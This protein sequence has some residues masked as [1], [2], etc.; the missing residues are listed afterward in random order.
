[1]CVCVYVKLARPVKLISG[2][3]NFK[4]N[5]H[6]EKIAEDD[7]VRK[8]KYTYLSRERNQDVDKNLAWFHHILSIV[9]EEL[10]IHHNGSLL[11]I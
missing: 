4:W 11:S 3:N 10:F 5:I 7:S 6:I 1:M 9:V 8:L 2:S